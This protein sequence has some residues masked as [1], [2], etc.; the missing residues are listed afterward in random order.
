MKKFI[1]RKLNNKDFEHSQ[2]K[3]VTEEDAES[4]ARNFQMEIENHH[5]A[6]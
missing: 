2:V 1:N 4:L 5:D 6:S 3:V